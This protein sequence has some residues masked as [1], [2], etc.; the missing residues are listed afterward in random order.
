M[1]SAVFNNVNENSVPVGNPDRI[2]KGNDSK[3]L[4]K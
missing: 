4:F 2:T 3:K 1:G